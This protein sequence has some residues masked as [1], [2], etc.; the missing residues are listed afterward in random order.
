MT[1]IVEND[2]QGRAG[3]SE[4]PVSAP[5]S[6]SQRRLWYMSQLSPGNPFYNVTIASRIEGQ[7]D[8]DALCQAVRDLVQRHEILRTRYPVEEGRPLQEVVALGDWQVHCETR[9]MGDRRLQE[10]E[11]QHFAERIAR[12]EIRLDEGPL[13]RA[14]LLKVA[15]DLHGLILLTHH[16]AIDQQSI[17]ILMDELEAVYGARL[18]GKRARLP[19]VPSYREFSAWQARRTSEREAELL[20]YSERILRLTPRPLPLPREEP[21]RDDELRLGKEHRFQVDS[22]QT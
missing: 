3:R 5:L 21:E 18:V 2:S 22:A 17:N 19:P 4:R 8:I 16:I 11:L 10:S 14:H 9:L 15:E 20:S 13:F 1:R 12:S 7:I 6:T